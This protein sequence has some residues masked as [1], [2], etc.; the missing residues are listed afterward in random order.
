[1]TTKMIFNKV[2]SKLGLILLL[3]TLGGQ[4][5]WA[6]ERDSTAKKLTTVSNP[7]YKVMGTVY[8]SKTNKAIA[9]ARV[10]Y[11]KN[12][13]KLTNSKGEFSM[14]IPVK[15]GV[16]EV[17]MDGYIPKEVP[18]L[19]DGKLRV[20][21]YPSGYRSLYKATTTVFGDNDVLASGGAVDKLE[22]DAWEENSETVGS[23]L[24]GK[25]AGVNVVRRS[26]TPGMGANVNI[27]GLSSIYTN[28]Q[29]LYIVDGIVYNAE[30]LSPS[31]TTGHLNNALQHIDVRDI[32]NVTV[33]KD[34]VAAS[35]YG[36][37]AANGIV[38]INTN[39]AREVA[40]Q[41]DLQANTGYNF[42]TK[43]LPLMGAYAYRSYLNDVLATSNHTGSEIA[44]MPFNN[45][46]P[47]F[48]DYAVYHNETNWQEKVLK[49]SIDQNYYLRVTGGD[50]IAK[51]A[52]S[53]GYNDEKGVIDQTSQT[54]YTAR[55]NGDMVLTKKFT[56]QSNISIGYGQQNLKDQGLSPK[57]NP[58]F[59]SLIKA[60]ILNTNEI[61]SD[62]TVSPNYA[63]ADYFGYSNPMQIIHN[64]INN[65]KAYR[66]LGSLVFNYEFSNRFKLSNLT[67]VTYDKAQESFFIPK[68]GVAKDTVNNIEVFSRLGTQVA[69]YYSISNDLRLQYKQDFGYSGKLQA[70]GGIRYHKH[71]SEQDYALGYNSATDQLVSIGNST[72]VSRTYGGNIGKWANMT[73]YGLA[74]FT[75]KDRYIFNGSIALD[76]SSRFGDQVSE[77]VR[78]A[79]KTYALFPAVA[80]A[81]VLSNEDFLKNSS[82]VNLAKLRLSYGLVGNDDIGNYNARQNY[83]SQN[84]LGVQGL[85]RDG[86]SNPYL[87]WEKVEKINAGF[88]L[89]LF[90]ERLNLTVDIYQNTTRDMLAYNPGNTLSGVSY[91]LYNNGSMRTKGIDVSLFGRLIDGSVKWDAGINLGHYKSRM[92]SM[93]ETSFS[94]YAGATYI[95]ETGGAPNA[96]YGYE[97][98]GVYSTAAEASAAGLSVLDAA[99][100]KV[101]FKAGDAKF[102]DRNG[103]KIIDDKDRM[104][105]GDPDPDLVGGL[106]NIVSYKNWKFGA[107]LTFSLGNDIY[108]YT[109]AQLESGSTF[110]NQTELLQNRWRAEGQVTDVPKATYND[111]M[112]NS[113]FSNRWIE[114]GSYLRLRQISVEYGIPVNKKIIK[115]VRLYGTANNLFTISKYLGY[116]PEFAQSADVYHQG[117]DVTLEPLVRSVQLGLRLGL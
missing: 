62:G 78:I 5:T 71:D 27:R 31:I 21:L 29:P 87:K 35:I 17:S 23:Y 36:A 88:D 113:R 51:Y 50:D 98:E 92:L 49:S 32:Q 97:F 94:H 99:G 63:D 112:G 106:S 4:A 60:P 45:D 115:Y 68:K 73:G 79:D 66:L 65:K 46:N 38:V 105:I 53:V 85:I 116:D 2:S 22:F 114:D 48:A 107:L 24:Q 12:V 93:P 37:K 77:G 72:A 111:P 64:G 52:L 40:T 47:K 70:I 55:F 103:D 82:K 110:Y 28:N 25:M 76:G 19:K 101:A 59:L 86:V 74:N 26:G 13:A 6:Q 57:T 42:R 11:G 8:D 16:V 80:G 33:L 75:W 90:Q 81:W 41:I 95:T 96:F 56:A 39:H 1:M 7:Q 14:D 43:S 109:R 30:H 34:A 67:T 102:N 54:R 117:I 9:G 104:V 69:R 91:Y 3:T 100:N 89:A 83:V 20:T 84:F 18:I 44:E 15:N 58:L 10:T 61:S 108:N